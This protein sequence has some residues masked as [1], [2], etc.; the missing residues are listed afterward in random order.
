MSYLG[1]INT[2]TYE[3]PTGTTLIYKDG[4][5]YK[6][7]TGSAEAA[8]VDASVLRLLNVDLDDDLPC[9]VFTADLTAAAAKSIVAYD[10][11]KTTVAFANKAAA[12][13][14][15]EIASRKVDKTD[16]LSALIDTK[17]ALDN[18]DSVKQT[19]AQVSA[20]ISAA[21]STAETGYTDAT[22]KPLINAAVASAFI[23][24]GVKATVADLPVTGNDNVEAANYDADLVAGWVYHVTATEGEYVY[25]GS[26]W[27][28]LGS[29]HNGGNIALTGYTPGNDD[30]VSLAATDTINAAF[31][32]V[33]THLNALDS[34][35]GGSASD[36]T[37]LAG[38]VTTAEG[39]IDVLQAA[40]AG[41][42]GTTTVAAAIAAAQSA[43][44]ST[45]SGDAT[46]KANAAEA[47][48][49]S[50]ADGLDT[51]MDA[52]VDV[53]EAAAAG[54]DGTTTIASAIS[55]A[56]SAAEST[57][58]GDATTKANAAESAAKAY[59]DGLV[60]TV[61]VCKSGTDAVGAT[62]ASPEAVNLA[63]GKRYVVIGAFTGTLPAN[64]A[65]G[66][67]IQ[68]SVAKGGA[69]R[70][71]IVSSGSTDTI[72]G[73]ANPCAI[74]IDELGLPSA[75]ENYSFVCVHKTVSDATVRDWVIL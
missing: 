39:E 16:F 48:A 67:I 72:N 28:E 63:A 50:Y 65:E 54:Y 5:A 23:F 4:S 30:A 37:A 2:S 1:S 70:K 7:K 47:A 27:D 52:R 34:L 53:L 10:N 61:V 71:V 14:T 24:K 29:L 68:V 31:G 11:T 8:T 43:A 57:A 45:A 33:V 58:A 41:Y 64:A 66:T 36:L 20:A 60:N 55:A 75:A 26:T 59:A 6:S 22:V 17:A 12:R 51:A 19:A 35:T 42:D 73:S 62:P 56:Q 32:K 40:T 69:D 25:N 38:R 21:L 9:L 15:Q 13:Y 74:G 3:S 49:K 18:L 44:E 46:T